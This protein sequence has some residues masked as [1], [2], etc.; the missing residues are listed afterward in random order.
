MIPKIDEINKCSVI[1]DEVV[2]CWLLLKFYFLVSVEKLNR[3]IPI[4]KTC[5]KLPNFK[6]LVRGERAMN[7]K[8]N[9]CPCC[10]G[11]TVRHV[12]HRELYWFCL[13]CRQEVPI[14]ITSSLGGMVFAPIKSLTI[15]KS[16]TLESE[17][18]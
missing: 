11:S 14:S 15:A 16:V 13:S 8:S 4:V 7:I 2:V 10:G 1:I 18:S 9:T 6:Q 12:R 17:R 3:K 5:F